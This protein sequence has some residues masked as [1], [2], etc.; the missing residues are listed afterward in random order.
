MGNVGFRE[1]SVDAFVG[2]DV[3]DEIVDDRNDRVFSAKPVVQR[4]FDG[5]RSGGRRSGGSR[6]GSRRF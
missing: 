4:F 6:I 3:T 2:G 5:C 1:A